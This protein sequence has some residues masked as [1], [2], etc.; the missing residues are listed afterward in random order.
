MKLN[1]GLNMVDAET[2]VTSDP[3]VF[4]GGDA[5]IFGSLSV[6]SAVAAGRRAAEAINRYLG[7]KKHLSA[8]KKVEHLSRCGEDS[9]GKR[10][11]VE[12][13]EL[14]LA[15]LS[16]EKEDILGLNSEAVKSDPSVVLTAA[17]WRSIHPTWRLPWWLWMPVS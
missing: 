17:A 7:G 8:D 5:T 11:R 12:T 2:Q 6:V 15:Q 1:R 16:L 13:P 9:L 14:P 10:E 4:A 3:K